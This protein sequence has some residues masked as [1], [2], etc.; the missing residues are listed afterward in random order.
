MKIVNHTESDIY[1]QVTPSGT[2]LSGS[3][4]IASGVVKAHNTIEFPLENAG[5]RPI[6]YAKGA[7]AYS[8]GNLST[9]VTDGHSTVAIS[10]EEVKV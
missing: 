5:N 9:Q 3:K 2:V 7:S 4:V 8:Q 1:Y 10:M 6:V